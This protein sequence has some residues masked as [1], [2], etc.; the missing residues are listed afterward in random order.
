LAEAIRMVD[1]RITDGINVAD[2]LLKAEKNSYGGTKSV[3]AEWR[4]LRNW[5]RRIHPLL[6]LSTSLVSA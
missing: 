3:V 1:D 6:L 5:W 4:G 2:V